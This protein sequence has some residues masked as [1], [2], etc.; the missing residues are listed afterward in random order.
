MR[1]DFF[2]LFWH[3]ITFII[4]HPSKSRI[5][6]SIKWFFSTRSEFSFDFFFVNLFPHV[7]VLLYDG[8]FVVELFRSSREIISNQCSLVCFIRHRILGI[9][10]ILE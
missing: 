8:W 10:G 6:L 4:F 9:L 3:E 1:Y 7:V 5:S 2:S